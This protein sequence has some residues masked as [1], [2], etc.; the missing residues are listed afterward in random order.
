M[1]ESFEKKQRKFEAEWLPRPFT[2][3]RELSIQSSGICFTKEGR[4]TLVGHGT[5][6]LLPGGYPEKNETLEEALIREVA[7]EACAR[8]LDLEYLGSVKCREL[9][10]VKEGNLP[11]F[12]QARY[13]V[14]VENGV[15]V[16]EHEISERTEIEPD[17]FVDQIQWPAKRLAERILM[18]ALRVNQNRQK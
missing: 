9:P 14:L 18:D 13:W 3:P 8:V 17:D 1:I 15:F 10:P 16:Q 4:I 2:P 6:W 7:E 12:Y 5:G 11:L